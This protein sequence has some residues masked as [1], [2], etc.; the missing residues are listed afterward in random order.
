[1]RDPHRDVEYG[2]GRYGWG[3]AFDNLERALR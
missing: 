2:G 3:T 1:M